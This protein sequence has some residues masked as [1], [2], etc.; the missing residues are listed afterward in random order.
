[1]GSEGRVLLVLAGVE[2]GEAEADLC[3]GH[4]DAEDDEDDDDPRDCAHLGVVDG[5]GE[6]LGQVEEDAASLVEDL[7][8]GV[9]LEILSD[10]LVQRVESRLRVPEEIG[11]VENIRR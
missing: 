3:D 5:V 4:E 7:D 6:D 10:G 9:D 11:D 1:M 2:E 8:P